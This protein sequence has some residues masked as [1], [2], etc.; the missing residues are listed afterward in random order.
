[1]VG[2]AFWSSAMVTDVEVG[3]RVEE[4]KRWVSLSLSLFP[5][6]CVLVSLWEWSLVGA[7]EEAV[8]AG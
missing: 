3:R 7:V 4:S 8:V 2:F 5:F 6:L 1:M